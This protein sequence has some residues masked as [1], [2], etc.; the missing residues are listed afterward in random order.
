[1]QRMTN[2]GD[3]LSEEEIRRRRRRAKAERM[4]RKR[5]LRRLVILGM[6]LIVAA[7]VGAGILIYRNTYT[8]VVNRGKRAEIN[9]N[10]T[11]AEALYLKAIEKKG[12]KKEAYFRLASLYHDQ[13]KDDDAD[14]LLQEAVD[15]HPDSVGVYQAMVEYYEDTDQTE[16][17]AYLM[18]T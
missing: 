8:G 9:G 16:K 10:D 4:R 2:P 6:I 3:R 7:V 18:S 11:K 12:E 14:A 13:N 1:M 17:I 5:R 15:S